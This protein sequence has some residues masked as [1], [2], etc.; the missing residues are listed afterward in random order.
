MN[1]ADLFTMYAVIVSVAVAYGTVAFAVAMWIE[2]GGLRRRR[3]ARA[4][5]RRGGR[6]PSTPRATR[7]YR[8]VRVRVGRRSA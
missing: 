3:A 8:A 5:A 4:R 6:E 7:I 2:Q 1:T